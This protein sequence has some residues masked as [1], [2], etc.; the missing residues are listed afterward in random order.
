MAA[1]QPNTF[2]DPDWQPVYDLLDQ[3]DEA[4]AEWELDPVQDREFQRHMLKL[5]VTLEFGP[6]DL[7]ANRNGYL[8][9]SQ[10]AR[11]QT[12]MRRIYWIGLI[13]LSALVFVLGLIGINALPGGWFILALS[14]AVMLAALGLAS[15]LPGELRSL[16]DRPVQV[17][18][19]RIGRL[20]LWFRRWGSDEGKALFKAEGDTP[21]SA[22]SNLYKVLRAN[23]DYRAYYMR[24]HRHWGGHRIISMEPV[25]KWSADAPEPK[26]KHK[27]SKFKRRR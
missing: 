25:G 3:P 5:A 15:T 6:D 2:E 18:P 22:P 24:L 10:I 26:T 27:R 21:V 14:V 8:S 20:S 4:E 16:P 12:K 11:F 19:I 9:P 23:Q 7:E 1:Y 17:T 13:A